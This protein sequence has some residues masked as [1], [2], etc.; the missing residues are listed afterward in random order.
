[1]TRCFVALG[2]NL[3]QPR[4]QLQ[5]ALQELRHLEGTSIVRC[6]QGYSSHAVGPGEQPDYINA[7]AEL[8]TRLDADSLLRA[9][10]VIE[11]AHGRVRNERWGARTLDLDILLYGE[12]RIERPHLQVPHLRM[13][14]R[15]FVLYP[16]HAIAPRLTLPCG[17]T[18]ESLLARCPRGELQPIGELSDSD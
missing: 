2:S 1:M 8:E 5:T 10:Q 11:S 9:L 4:Q 15:A 6:S 7:V 12:E 3:D 18:L 13:Q 17:T 14:D 16:L